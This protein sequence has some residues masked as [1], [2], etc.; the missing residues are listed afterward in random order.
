[1]YKSTINGYILAKTKHND[2]QIMKMIDLIDK[3][4]SHYQNI[5]HN[6]RA[7]F[8]FRRSE[9]PFRTGAKMSSGECSDK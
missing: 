3:Y 8:D 4:K 9:I 1:M 5:H 7:T 6:A 2:D